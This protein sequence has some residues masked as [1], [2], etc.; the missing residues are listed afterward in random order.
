[1]HDFANNFHELVNIREDFRSILQ[2]FDNARQ[3]FVISSKIWQYNVRICYC[4]GSF[5]IWYYQTFFYNI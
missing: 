5:D 1:M 3:D 4:N 2:D